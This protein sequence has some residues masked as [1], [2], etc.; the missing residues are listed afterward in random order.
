ML[1][2][3]CL[4]VKQIRKVHTEIALMFFGPS[5][6]ICVW[7]P[8]WRARSASACVFP[9]ASIKIWARAD[10]LHPGAFAPEIRRGLCATASLVLGFGST[11][12]VM[13]PHAD[14]TST[15]KIKD[16]FPLCELPFHLFFK[17]ISFFPICDKKIL[18]V[19]P[20]WL[21][22]ESNQLDYQLKPNGV[23]DQQRVRSPEPRTCR[24]V[25][26][27]DEEINEKKA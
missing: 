10:E 18:T 8:F 24:D 14:V 17:R 5:G 22:A 19:R 26:V 27:T 25:I 9:I 16:L 4:V 23:L 21:Q 12:K 7:R 15:R 13:S 2:L 20:V 1:I 11:I 3:E 6:Y